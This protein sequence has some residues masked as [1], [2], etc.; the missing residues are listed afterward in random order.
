MKDLFNLC[1][2]RVEHF[3][4]RPLLCATGVA[5]IIYYYVNMSGDGEKKT[6]L[7]EDPVQDQAVEPALVQATKDLATDLAMEV[8][9]DQAME[10]ALVHHK[11]AP[12]DQTME[13]AL[14][15]HK[16][17]PQ[18]QAMERPWSPEQACAYA[19]CSAPEEFRHVYRLS[20]ASLD[21]LD[22]ASL[23]SSSYLT[24]SSEISDSLS[25]TEEKNQKLE[26]SNAQL[27][28]RVKELKGLL[29]KAHRKCEARTMSEQKREAHSVL[30][31]EYDQ[32]K[33][34][35]TH[36]DELPKL[37][38]SD[39]EQK[40]KK[41]LE[42]IPQLEEEK[43][44]LRH[45]VIKLRAS[46]QELGELL[47]QA[48]SEYDELIN[49]FERERQ[50]H[51]VLQSQYNEMK[52]NEQFLKVSLP[53]A[54]QKHQKSL[55]SITQ[56]EEKKSELMHQ[57]N[58][59][60]ASVQEPGELPYQTQREYAELM[61]CMTMESIT[62][63]EEEKSELRHEVIKLRA[64]LQEQ[65]E[66]LD[67]AY[68]EYDELINEYE[69]EREAHSVVLL[70]CEQ[71]KMT[72]KQN[73]EM[74]IE[75]ERERQ[76]HSVLQSQYNEMKENEQFLKVSLPDAEQKHQ[77]SLESITQLEEKKSEL[78]HQLNAVHASVQEPGELPYQTQREYA[79]LMKAITAAGLQL[80]ARRE[81]K[82]FN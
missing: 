64:S 50:S 29:C 55:E 49:E 1:G 27:E 34:M 37:L 81:T 46:V 56:L 38:L 32:M 25:A 39:A 23:S 22:C 26:A 31:V 75:F 6:T 43:S 71:M 10:P 70:E 54:E 42:S 2:A 5:A 61:K 20:G 73:E 30:L 59:V 47:Y 16:E 41:A 76:S 66:L 40:H 57:L 65:G 15:Q 60:H 13:P 51:S 19:C 28:D 35:L 52:E 82:I 53:D 44:E 58:A 3:P 33:E 67:Q 72:L 4:L 68:S 77:K 14:V 79:E 11:E 69:R 17:A 48:Y 63:L 7:A 74:L 21:S 78:M 24:A 12:Q 18:D 36:K 8:R 62:Q 80:P 9:Q 45:E